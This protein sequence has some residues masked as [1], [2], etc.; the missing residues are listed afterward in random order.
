MN[1]TTFALFSTKIPGSFLVPRK[2]KKHHLKNLFSLFTDYTFTFILTVCLAEFVKVYAG[3][4]LSTVSTKFTVSFPAVMSFITYPLVTF[5]YFM[6]SLVLNDGQTIGTYLTKQ[7]FPVRDEYKQA[8]LLTVNS[9]T[10][11]LL[12]FKLMDEFR[13]QDYRYE[14]L[15]E[16]KYQTISL[17]TLIE[18]EKEDHQ[19]YQIA[20]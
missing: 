12:Y 14:E 16:E 1:L 20:A 13:S 5:T 15:M 17:H 19:D 2:K 18:E 3:I 7:R 6:M 9:L 8:L 4:Y 10:L 11:N